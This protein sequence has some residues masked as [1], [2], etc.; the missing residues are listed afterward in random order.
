ML[1][2]ECPLARRFL[3]LARHHPTAI[4]VRGPSGEITTRA[5]LAAAAL[6]FAGRARPLL[7]LG[8]TAVVSL[9]N[10]TSLVAAFIGLRVAGVTV[11]LVDATAPID[12]LLGCARA[13]GAGLI[14][15]GKRRLAEGIAGPAGVDVALA[16]YECEPVPSPPAAAVLKLTSGSTGNPRAIAVGAHQL[17]ADTIQIMRT[18]GVRADDTTLAAIPLTHSY[19]IGSCLMPLL[20]AGTPLVLPASPLPAALA[21]ALAEGRVTHFP[22]VPAMIRALAGLSTLPDLSLLRVCLSAGAPLKPHDA[23]AFHAATGTKVHVFYGSSECGGITYDRADAPVHAEGAVGT[24]MHRVIVEVVD[25]FGLCVRHGQQGRVRVRSR[26]VAIAAVPPLEDPGVLASGVFLT[27]DHGIFDAAGG[28]TLTGRVA[29]QLNIAGKKVHP[30]EVRRVLEAI[31][32]VRA[33]HVAGLPDAH[34]GELVAAVVAVDPAAGLTVPAILAAC[35]SR[36]APHKL[37]RRIVLVDELPL[38][39]RGKIDSNAICSLLK[40]RHAR[41]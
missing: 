14:V 35:R 9:P 34:R 6:A 12:E 20:L 36:L 41:I 40:R 25:D 2:G 11:A 37:P 1:E 38:T 10:A 29:Q 7:G 26:A 16:P 28:L 13:V 31:A 22:A 17:V 4:A 3:A 15:A 8:R 19:G 24:A 32:G 21:T 18:M 33:A 39:D 5:E 27:S 23:A 30:E